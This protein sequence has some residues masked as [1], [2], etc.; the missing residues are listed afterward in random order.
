M[1]HKTKKLTNIFIAGTHTLTF[2]YLARNVNTTAD[3]DLLKHLQKH[4][5]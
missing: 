5:L 1:E 3:V 2:Y 4:K